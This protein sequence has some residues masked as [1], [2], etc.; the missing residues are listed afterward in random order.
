MNPSVARNREEAKKEEW[1]AARHERIHASFTAALAEAVWQR[2]RAAE[3]LARKENFV[4]AAA[5]R[6]ACRRWE[7]AEAKRSQK[8]CAACD[9]W[10]EEWQ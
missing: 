10:M 8:K 1:H 4:A 2:S 5:L 3:R 7:K 6:K 9:R